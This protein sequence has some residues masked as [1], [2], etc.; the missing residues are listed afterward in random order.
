[1]DINKLKT[2]MMVLDCQSITKAARKLMR[3][4]SAI[5]QQSAALEQELGMQL[6]D[7][8]GK[9]IYPTRKGQLIYEACKSHVE[10]IEEQVSQIQGGLETR[11]G[12]LKI[13]LRPDLAVGLLPSILR[14]FSKK[15]PKVNIITVLGNSQEAEKS[16]LSGGADFGLILDITQKKLLNNIEFGPYDVRLCCSREYA[17]RWGEISGP[18][19][20]LNQTIIGYEE[21]ANNLSKLFPPSNKDRLLLKNKETGLVVSDS[22]VAKAFVLNHLGICLLPDFLI[23]AELQKNLLIDMFPESEM[24]ITYQAIFRKKANNSIIATEF[25]RALQAMRCV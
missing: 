17:K 16:V 22:L 6:L 7:R 13:A 19:D 2:Y 10:S 15:L 5:T 8:V 1:M 18:K 20:L 21:C 4:Q 11:Q 9:N 25:I 24:K 12:E 23:E 3:T 14:D